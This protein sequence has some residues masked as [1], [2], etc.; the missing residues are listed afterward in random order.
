MSFIAKSVVFDF[1]VNWGDTKKGVRSIEFFLD[2]T[3]ISVD[4]GTCVCYAKSEYSTSFTA[5][6]AFYT[7][8]SKVDSSANTSWLSSAAQA[9]QNQRLI[10]VFN[11]ETEFDSIVINNYHS[12][13]GSL[14]RA[15]KNTK[16]Y[17][18]TSSITNTTYGASIASGILIF[19]DT[20][21]QHVSSN[22][23]DDIVLSLVDPN[24]IIS[25][26]SVVSNSVPSVGDI[27]GDA[28]TPVPTVHAKSFASVGDIGLMSYAQCPPISSSSTLDI[29]SFSQKLSCPLGVTSSTLTISSVYD[30]ISAGFACSRS[31]GSLGDIK[32]RDLGNADVRF[33]LTI[34]G[35]ND[36]LE[37]IEIP[38]SSFQYRW[39]YPGTRFIQVVV[40]TLDYA[41]QISDR[42]NGTI[43]VSRYF[44]DY[45]FYQDLI[46]TFTIYSLRPYRGTT[47]S[48]IVLTG[49]AAGYPSVDPSYVPTFHYIDAGYKESGGDFPMTLTWRIPYYPF[50]AVGSD[51]FVSGSDMLRLLSVNAT[52][53]ADQKDVTIRGWAYSG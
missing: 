43:K 19:D 37:D 50:T 17:T 36:G 46:E 52:Y 12:Y 22:V 5:E 13:G 9:Y 29:A 41:D 11:T 31:T 51:V 7:S 39:T 23:Q 21:R 25:C 14:D 20:I 26:P 1:A 38:M 30:L 2:G 18:S 47:N 48:S 32:E 34:T 44:P 33:I 45:E 53:T 3:L 15:V 40:P 10:I 16:I 42:S 4:S 24:I 28:S 35:K 49:Y 27:I 8:L 6:M